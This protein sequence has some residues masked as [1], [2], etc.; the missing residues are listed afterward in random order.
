MDD[1]G[2]EVVDYDGISDRIVHYC[3]ENGIAYDS[4]IPLSLF[5]NSKG[6]LD[7]VKLI[8][9]FNDDNSPLVFIPK[10]PIPADA[11]TASASG[12]DPDISRASAETQASRVAHARGVP[13]ETIQQVIS[14]STANP[15]LGFLG[16]PRVNVLALNIALDS[17]FPK[18]R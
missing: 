16:E 1:K 12:L 4:S 8:K 18:R 6:D 13:V 3:V 14:A 10:T 7:D 11:V 2:N 9:A 17:Q 15:D 5:M